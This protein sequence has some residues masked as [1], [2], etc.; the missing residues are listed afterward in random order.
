MP[1]ALPA[2]PLQAESVL[3]VNDPRGPYIPE[4]GAAGP[5]PEKKG[6]GTTQELKGPREGAAT[7]T[8]SSATLA[9]SLRLVLTGWLSDGPNP[10]RPD[11]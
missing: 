8:P 10:T 2:A 3:A 4:S 7:F 9:V 1:I 6:T 5:S 11:L